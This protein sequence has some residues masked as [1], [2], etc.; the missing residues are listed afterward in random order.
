MP[1]AMRPVEFMEPLVLRLFPRVISPPFM[2]P[3]YFHRRPHPRNRFL[4]LLWSA[5]GW[6]YELVVLERVVEIPFVLRH[7][8]PAR[9]TAVLDFGCSRSPL[10][11]SLASLGYAVTGIDLDPYPLRH[12]DLRFVRADFLDQPFEAAAFDAV[13]ALSA[14]EH[15]GLGAYGEA[16]YERGDER[17]MARIF[18]VLKPGGRLLLTVPYGRAG[19]TSWYRVYDHAGLARLLGAFRIADAEYYVGIGRQAWRPASPEQLAEVDSVECG[20]AQGVAC[21]D[22]V[23]PWQAGG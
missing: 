11:I 16:P 5:L 3:I 19:Q 22:A 12:P 9:G 2:P 17:A 4:R 14:V 18:E 21:I 7:L 8:P 13:V 1:G 6:N 10:A 20:F 15:C 23:K